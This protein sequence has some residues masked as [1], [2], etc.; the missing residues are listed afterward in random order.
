MEQLAARV[1]MSVRNFSRV[2]RGEY[3]VSPGVFVERLRFDTARRLVEESQ[4]GFDDIAAECGLGSV[5]TLRRLFLRERGETP[6][7]FR[8][9]SRDP[10]L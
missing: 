2:F 10:A 5:E 3:G 6:A 1:A 4:R 9:R 8:R 7:Q